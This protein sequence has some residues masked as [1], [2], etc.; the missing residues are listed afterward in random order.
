MTLQ[1]LQKCATPDC[2]RRTTANH[3][4]A[5]CATAHEGHYEIHETGLL[6]HSAGCEERTRERERDQCPNQ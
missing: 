2:D 6:A 3:C 5:P 1:K 4:C